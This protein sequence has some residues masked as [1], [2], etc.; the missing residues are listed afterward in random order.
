MNIDKNLIVR[1]KQ[2]DDNAWD[3]LVDEYY[4]KLLNYC[5]HSVRYHD[6]AEDMVQNVF[7]KAKNSISN[8]TVDGR[9]AVTLGPW[10]WTITKNTIRDYYRNKKIRNE[11]MQFPQPSETASARNV[12]EVIDGHT[13]PRTKAGKQDRHR[14]LLEGLD[15]IDRKYSEVIFLR[16]I[17]GLSRKEMAELLGVAEDTVKTRLRRALEKVKGLLPGELY[18]E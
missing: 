10:L 9:A 12:L 3:S 11:R 13:G 17:D 5:K 15:K 6:E 16:Y 1:L 7:I 14:M 18:T 2:C 4:D 8:F